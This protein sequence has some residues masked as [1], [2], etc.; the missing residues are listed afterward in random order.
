[1]YNA[2]GG[3]LDFGSWEFWKR[4]VLV[5]LFSDVLVPWTFE[6]TLTILCTTD[7]VSYFSVYFETVIMNYDAADSLL[8]SR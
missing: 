4:M 1:M 8:G 6:Y 5:A 3:I 2:F 7:E